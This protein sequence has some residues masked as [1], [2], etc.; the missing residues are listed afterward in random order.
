MS[1]D[2]EQRIV[3]NWLRLRQPRITWTHPPNG[4]WRNI[5]TARRLKLLGTRPGCPD[6]I[7]WTPPP[8][9]PSKVGTAIEMKA[10]KG[11]VSPEQRQFMAELDA[12]N[13]VTFVAHGAGIAIAKLVALGY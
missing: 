3:A 5:V 9:V 7:L 1:E 4:G 6:L 2:A 10:A 11:R 8:N 12:C 13:W